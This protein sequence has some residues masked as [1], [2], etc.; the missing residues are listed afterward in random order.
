METLSAAEQ[1][2]LA[3]IC[4]EADLGRRDIA[5][6]RSLEGEH[7]AYKTLGGYYRATAQGRLN[8]ESA[9]SVALCQE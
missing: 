8:R 3:E 6:Y 2:T 5:V 7:L 4:V 1:S 9:N